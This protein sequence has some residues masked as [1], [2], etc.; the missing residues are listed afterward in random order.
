MS[1]QQREAIESPGEP[2]ERM[3]PTSPTG[4]TVTKGSGGNDAHI[5]RIGINVGPIPPLLSHDPEDLFHNVKNSTYRP[6]RSLSRLSSFRVF[7]TWY[8]ANRSGAVAHSPSEIGVVGHSPRSCPA[9]LPQW[10]PH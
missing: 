5:I 8:K 1:R 9:A 3:G 2:A 4:P 10:K 7:S 6:R